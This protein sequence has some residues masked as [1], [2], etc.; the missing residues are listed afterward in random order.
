MIKSKTKYYFLYQIIFFISLFFLV[1]PA[2]ASNYYINNRTGNDNG[3]GTSKDAPWKSFKNL[4]IK[5]FL[6]GDSILFAKGSSYKGGFIFKSSGIEGKPIVFSSYSAGASDVLQTNRSE[7]QNI[8][9]RLGAGPAPAFTNPDWNILN[10]NIFQI[11]G[12]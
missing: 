6:P 4:Q 2:K 9:L 12:S 5:K 8:F 10:G 11:H 3:A 1:H 7:L